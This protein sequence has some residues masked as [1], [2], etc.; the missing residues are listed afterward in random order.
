MGMKKLTACILVGFSVMNIYSKNELPNVIFI[1][2]DD[3]GYGDLSC[4]NENS[5]IK[6]HF[7]DSVFS[8]GLTFL[9]AHSN[10]SVSTPS[11]YGIMTG[12]YCWRSSLERGVLHGYSPALIESDRPTVASMLKE[13]GYNTAC[14]GKW[15]LGVDG[16][17]SIDGKPVD[18]YGK[19][20]DFKNSKLQGS[21]STGFDY[22]YGISASLDMAPYLLIED[23][24]VIEEPTFYYEKGKTKKNPYGRDGHAIDGRHPSFFLSHF[25]DKVVDLIGKYSNEDKP[26]FIYFPLN[27]PHAPIA[28]HKDFIGKSGAGSHG[29]YVMEVDKRVSQV[30]EALKKNG[31][32]DNTIVIFTSDNGPEVAAYKR[33]LDTGHCS[34]GDLKGVKRDLWEGGHRVPMLLIWPD[35]IKKSR[36]IVNTVCLLDFYATMAD[37]VNHKIKDGECPDS[38]SYLPLINGKDVTSRKYTIHHSASGRFAIRQGDWVLI[39]KGSGNDNR[40]TKVQEMYYGKKSYPLM[41]KNNG[42]L[43]YLKELKNLYNDRLDKVNELLEILRECR[44]YKN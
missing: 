41:E 29:D 37:I 24:R 12:R 8:N 5:K 16:W 34:S 20:V 42:E 35:K 25:T 36:Q 17:K 19:N 44:N 9:D 39:E 13:H 31:V 22:F 30:Y 11:R 10:S 32:A 3:L 33:F 23:D 18:R 15:H 4:L 38:Y 43:F 2:A 14:V 27:A 26:F 7:L 21:A 28:P 6:T 1:F 40:N